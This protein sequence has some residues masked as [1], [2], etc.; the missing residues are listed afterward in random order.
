VHAI[1]CSVLLCSTMAAVISENL[2]AVEAFQFSFSAVRSFV[3]FRLRALHL[4]S[5]ACLEQSILIHL[6]AANFLSLSRLCTN[7]SALLPLFCFIDYFRSAPSL[8]CMCSC[9]MQCAA[10]DLSLPMQPY[11]FNLISIY[12]PAKSS[13]VLSSPTLCLFLGHLP[14]PLC[15]LLLLAQPYVYL[16]P[17]AFVHSLVV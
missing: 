9:R 13:P 10:S 14:S 2:Q 4:L 12:H 5:C 16:F 3:S 6:S 11:T 8:L 17:S 1:L 7:T 15:S